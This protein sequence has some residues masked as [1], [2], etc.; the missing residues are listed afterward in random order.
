MENEPAADGRI[1][2]RDVRKLVENELGPITD[3]EFQEM[4]RL[5]FQQIVDETVERLLT[6]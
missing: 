6:E 5:A 1:R 2:L 4:F 3:E